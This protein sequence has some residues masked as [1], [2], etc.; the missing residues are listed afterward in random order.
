MFLLLLENTLNPVFLV[1]KSQISCCAYC[2]S[3]LLAMMILSL[4]KKDSNTFLGVC[5]RVLVPCESLGL[6]FQC[7]QHNFGQQ[8]LLRVV[9]L[10]I[11]LH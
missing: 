10:D 3:V 8:F 4:W 9:V 1:Y 5:C 7:E 11:P 2:V 6:L